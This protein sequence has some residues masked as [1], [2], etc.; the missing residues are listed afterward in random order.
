M[1][2]LSA[3]QRGFHDSQYVSAPFKFRESRRNNM[4]N[5]TVFG[6]YLTRNDAEAAVTA[7]QAANFASSDVSVLLPQ[8]VESQ[9]LPTQRTT[10]A[11]AAATAGAGSGAVVGGTIGW[12]AG[13]GALVI[14]GIGPFLAV[15]PL[16]ATLI[17]AGVGGA[18]GGAA[19]GLIGLGIPEREAKIYEGRLLKGAILVAVQCSAHEQAAQAKSVLAE[20]GAENISISGEASD[21]TRT[22]A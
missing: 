12:L 15:G 10:K 21:L 17:G 16:V 5:G 7:L 8:D 4:A 18:V 14:P 3:R 6:I 22:A 20:T 2:S 13:M 9:N 11:P 1:V 19:G